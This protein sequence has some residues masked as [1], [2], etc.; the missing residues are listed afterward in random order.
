MTRLALLLPLLAL[1]AS[2]QDGSTSANWP[3]YLGT[4]YGW[5]HSTLNQVTTANV[6][7]LVPT[8]VFQ[9]GDYEGGLQVTPIVIDGVMYISTSRNRVF[10]IN[11]ATGQEQ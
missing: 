2:A 11:A 7:R 6:K 10:A 5:R 3:N 4:T 9:T 1:I 8:W